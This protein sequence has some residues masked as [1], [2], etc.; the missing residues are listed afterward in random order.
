MHQQKTITMTLIALM[1]AVTCILAPIS[2]TIPISVVP[3]S[4]T[5]L[6]V[7]IS[8][9]ILG[10]KKGTVSYLVYLLIGLVGLPV[11]SSFSSGPA[12]LLGPTGGYLIGF[13]FM[14]LIIG[15][16]VDRF[17]DKIYMYVL[18][19]IL[20]TIVAYAFGTGWLAYQS[21]MTFTAAFFAGVVPFII[22]DIAKIIIASILGVTTKKQLKRAGYL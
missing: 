18:G 14:A 12:K 22:G 3:I 8:A 17:S 5:N 1:T 21:E 19:M 2:I 7:Y 6:A 9:I 10:W 11:F 20:G 16:F 4:F 15:F 13:I